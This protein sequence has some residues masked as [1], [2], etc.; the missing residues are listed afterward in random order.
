MYVEQDLEYMIQTHTRT[1]TGTQN[2]P[3]MHTLLY[4]YLH[5]HKQRESI[6]SLTNF[7]TL[8]EFD[9]L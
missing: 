3:H 8:H 2:A 4:T 5:T 9:K 6:V 7:S 1:H